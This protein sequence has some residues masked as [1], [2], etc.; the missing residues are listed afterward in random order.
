MF[1]VLFWRCT[2]VLDRGCSWAC[3]AAP[4]CSHITAALVPQ[5]FGR[6]LHPSAVVAMVKVRL[7]PDNPTD[8]YTR[9]FV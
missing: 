5:E 2:G 7:T 6:R 4:A 9:D 8:C 1:E 3:R